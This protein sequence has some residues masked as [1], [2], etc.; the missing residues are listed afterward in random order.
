ML[1]FVLLGLGVDD[2][3]VICNAYGRTDPR[4]PINERMSESLGH[5]GQIDMSLLF[6][7][8]NPFK[9]LWGIKYACVLNPVGENSLKCRKRRY[10]FFFY[11]SI[12]FFLFFYFF[13]VLAPSLLLRWTQSF[14]IFSLCEHVF[15]QPF[16]HAKLLGGMWNAPDKFIREC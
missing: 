16:V 1:P 8:S 11:F 7:E 2:S 6:D 15:C 4:K 9:F 5:S 12:F 10:F 14:G 13:V 3:F